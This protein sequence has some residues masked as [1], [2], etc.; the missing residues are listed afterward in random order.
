MRLI[1]FL[2]VI[3][4]I[5]LAGGS[6]FFASERFRAIEANLA[7]TRTDAAAAPQIETV[8]V[9]VATRPLKF[10]NVL[11]QEFVTIAD[12]PTES[13]PPTGFNDLEMLFGD[14]TEPRT[15][16]VEMQQGE[17]I[18][19]NKITGF[20]ERPSISA[21]LSEG[22]RAFSIPISSVSAVSGFVLPGDRVDIFLTRTTPEGDLVTDLILQNVL[23]IG[24][25]QLADENSNKPK[26][27]RTATVE[28]DPET[29]QKLALAQRLGSL[30]L[31]LRKVGAQDTTEDMRVSIGDVLSD[32][33]EDTGRETKATEVR[34]RRGN[35][36]ETLNFGE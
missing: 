6:V 1:A 13:A 33:D 26:V 24:V 25:D 16:L 3:V 8:S 35:E 21:K 32:F 15:V 4:G 10:G 9:V 18:L 14:G 12:W 31:S 19:Q 20:G 7:K 17:P 5:A 34:V 11:Q 23:V 28:V 22:M 36:V 30:S 27:G 29:A 2:I